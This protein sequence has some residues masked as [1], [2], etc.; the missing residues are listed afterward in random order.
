MMTEDAA[1][2][3][4]PD[5]AALFRSRRALAQAALDDP[6]L[7]TVLILDPGLAFAALAEVMVR[8]GY[9]AEPLPGEVPDLLAGEPQVAVWSRGGQ[10]PYALYS[11]NPVVR[12]RV[13]E[14]GTLP[15]LL[16][17]NLR[18]A[19]PVLTLSDLQ[20]TLRTGPDTAVLRS[21]WALVEREE[22][23]MI[24]PLQRLAEQHS[25]VVGDEMRLALDRLQA[26][27]RAR[28]AVLGG[29]RLVASAARQMIAA[30]ARDPALAQELLA[31][32]EDCA[33]LFTEDVAP[34]MARQLAAEPLQLGKGLPG[35]PPDETAI[36]A[37]PAGLLRSGNL[38]SRHFPVGYRLVAGWMLPD[39]VWFSWDMAEDGGGMVRHDGLVFLGNRWLWF[40]RPWRRIE[41]ALVG[42][43]R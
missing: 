42:L 1:D 29:M 14:V 43:G 4:P 27:D 36:T 30:M 25:G 32:P 18:R 23:G 22:V 8:Q 19:L 13:L 12:L 6:E 16:R 34:E 20:T 17:Q 31:R 33:A 9:R 11:F 10:R 7:G 40:P 37:A 39:R 28:V 5:A 21:V 24:A 26:I 3:P 35:Q 2:T 38:L 15:P 41:A